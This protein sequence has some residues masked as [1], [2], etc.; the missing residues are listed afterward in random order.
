MLRSYN[1]W[2]RCDCGRVRIASDQVLDQST[3]EEASLLQFANGG[4][5]VKRVVTDGLDGVENRDAAAAEHFEVNA[6]ALIHRFRERQTLVKKGACARNEI[7]H[8]AHVAVVKPPLDD[9]VFV[10]ALGGC[11]IKR[12]VNA[13]FVE[14]ARNVLPKIRELKCSTSGVR[15]ALALLV[16]IAAEVKDQAADGISRVNAVA[17]NGVP[18]RI[19][20]GGLILAKRLQ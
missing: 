1:P 19:A 9:I 18:V 13:A 3:A 6:E 4:T 17:E 14:V 5:L 10:K 15:K 8:E 2:H 12:N 11:S 7:L 20:L 16:T